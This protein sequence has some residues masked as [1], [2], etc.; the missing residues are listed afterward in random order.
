MDKK[1]KEKFYEQLV[2]ETKEDFLN[3]RDERLKLERKWELNMQF[4]NGN[5]YV[6]INSNGEIMD[7]STSFY[8]QKKEVF[9]HVAPIIETR[10]AKFSRIS[11]VLSVRPK[12]DDDVDTASANACEKIIK[13]VFTKNE[14]EKCVQKACKW[15]E[16]CG[17]AFYKVM[18]DNDGG[19]IIANV[20]GKEVYE[21][22]VK[23]IAVSPFEIFPDSLEVEEIEDCKS[24]IHARA[25]KV[26]EIFEKYKVQVDA[27]DVDVISF[28]QK[29]SA[30]VTATVKEKVIDSAIVIE[31]YEKPTLEFPNGRLIIVAGD[32][33][34]YYGEL[35]YQNDKNKKRTYPFIKQVAFTSAGSFFGTSL[36]ERLIPVQKAYNAVKNRKH[37]FLNRLSMGIMT[38]EDG[39]VDVEELQEEGLS[40]GKVLVYRQGAKA[41][42]IMNGIEMPDDFSNEEEKLLNEFVTISGVADVS[43]SSSN[44]RLN[45]G[46]ALELLVEQD[47]A[48][49]IVTAEIIRNCYQ[50]IA[51]HVIRLYAQFSGKVRAVKIKDKEQKSKILYVDKNSINSDDVYI[52]NENELL[53]T[54]DKKKQMI[55]ELYKSGILLDAKG[56]MRSVTKEKI[57]SLLGYQDLDYEK[58]VSRLHEEKAQYENP[59]IKN[60][61]LNVEEIDDDQIH[62]DEHVRYILS[63]YESLK[64]NEKQR[65]FEHLRAHKERIK[66]NKMEK[67]NER[68]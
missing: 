54:E 46:S 23:L 58:G 10:L 19:E 56:N 67:E 32:K 33:L 55:L 4:L 31:K 49:L 62:V 60:K 3:R 47:N 13:S 5:Q 45:S 27:E 68:N 2:I 48:R 34:L 59:I 11:P 38:V 7:S 22:E 29:K 14:I 51:K 26:K 12:T 17:T 61:G 66:L 50:N 36:I 1:E 39:S 20:D 6:Y 42:E 8:W 57:L 43:S 64:D 35:P 28:N 9:N 37:E 16:A 24:L 53:Y 25:V 21:G 18:W 41:P 40:P 63:E 65:L 30:G 52:E 44:A 15:S